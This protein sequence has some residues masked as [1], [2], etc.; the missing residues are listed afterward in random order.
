[1]CVFSDIII[2]MGGGAKYTEEEVRGIAL[3]IMAR[4]DDHGPVFWESLANQGL[5]APVLMAR[6][7]QGGDL[8]KFV[9]RHRAQVMLMVEEEMKKRKLEVVLVAIEV[10]EGRHLIVS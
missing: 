5:L 4:P 1:M 7:R 9:T 8:A 6:I 10:A 3:V 2:T